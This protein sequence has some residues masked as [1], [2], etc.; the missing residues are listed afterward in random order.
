M[1]DLDVD[2]SGSVLRLRLN[3]PEVLN[4]LSGDLARG[5]A[6]ALEQA[7]SRDDVRVVVLTGTGR[8]F[9]SGADLGSAG[10]GRAE[11]R[12]GPGAMD[13]AT[14]LIRAVVAS[15]KPVVAAVNG[16]AAG[17][18]CSLALACDLIVAPESA[19]FLLPFARVGLMIDGGASATVA[20]AIGRPR[21]MRMGLLAEPLSAAEAFEAGLITHL[22]TDDE[23]EA[24]VEAVVEQLRA[25]PPLAQTATKRAINAATL[26]HLDAALEREHRS[27]E[28]LLRTEDASEGIAAF[29]EGRS[30]TFRGD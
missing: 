21:A 11:D 29:T 15:D 20:A 18:S 10:D 4:A 17:V 16:I 27:Q 7:N 23:F 6:D 12:L 2:L 26:A 14:R 25:G 3:R 19:R 28:L 22:S 1:P 24:E 30:P 9:S 8:A 5:L 13:V